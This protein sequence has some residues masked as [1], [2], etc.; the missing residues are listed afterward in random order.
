MIPRIRIINEIWSDC[1]QNDL[2]SSPLYFK[3]DLFHDKWKFNKATASQ[4]KGENSPS[5][6]PSIKFY[7]TYRNC[8]HNIWD[9]DIPL[10]KFFIILKYGD[11][12]LTKVQYRY[13][14]PNE[15]L[16]LY[17]LTNVWASVRFVIYRLTSI[18]L[19]AFMSPP[20]S[21][22][23]IFITMYFAIRHRSFHKRICWPT[24]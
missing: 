10:P 1:S 11:P 24:Y 22:K 13:L 2:S 12:Q 19:Y 8:W 20:I 21:T 23:G 16:R 6:Q 4:K 17:Q 14:E 15:R 9:N 7:G 5:K 3:R 18:I